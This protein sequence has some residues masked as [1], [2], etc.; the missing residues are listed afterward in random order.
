[1]SAAGDRDQRDAELLEWRWSDDRSEDSSVRLPGDGTIRA[2]PVDGGLAIDRID[3][4]GQTRWTAHVPDADEASI[5]AGAQAAYVALY[6]RG[7]TGARMRAVDVET[8]LVLWEVSLEALGLFHHS[9]YANRVQ[10]RLVEEW[11]VVYGDESSG[12]YV[13]ARAATDGRLIGRRLLT[14]D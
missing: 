3:G 10:V 2:R 1:M 12:R 5:D 8:G 4:A 6:R 14:P 9:K 13:E 11:V 7:A